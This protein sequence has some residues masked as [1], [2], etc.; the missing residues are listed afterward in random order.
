MADRFNPGAGGVMDRVFLIC[1]TFGGTILVLRLAL[2][3]LGLGFESLD[4]ADVHADV[5][6][7]ADGAS[8][9]DAMAEDGQGHHAAL[10]KVFTFQ[11]IVAFVAFFGVGGLT[12]LE[13]KQPPAVATLVGVAAGAVAVFLLG[14]M[15]GALRNLDADGSVRIA[16]AVGLEGKVYLRIPGEGEGEGKVVLPIQGRIVAIPARTPGPGLRAGDPVVVSRVV[17]EGRHLVEVVVP[18]RYAAKPASFAD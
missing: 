4:G 16:N 17:D 8:G 9:H 2:S 18:E 15:L 14:A 5:D 10:G 13:L 3:L 1:L 11:A 7:H 6:L 12:A